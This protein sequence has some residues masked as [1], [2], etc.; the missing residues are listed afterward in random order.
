MYSR[1]LTAAAAVSQL[2]S[3]QSSHFGGNLLSI[4]RASRLR[5]CLISHVPSSLI[6]K[7]DTAWAL[8]MLLADRAMM[9][10]SGAP[11]RLLPS[12]FNAGT[13]CMVTRPVNPV[14]TTRMAS[15]SG[16]SGAGAFMLVWLMGPEV[17]EVPRAT[18]RVRLSV[19]AD[20]NG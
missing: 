1:C 19:I 18:R 8:S 16:V 6:M 9:L 11:N 7:N 17:I 3:V 20:I 5:N 2:S 10:M 13:S 12:S 14:E 4:A 15:S